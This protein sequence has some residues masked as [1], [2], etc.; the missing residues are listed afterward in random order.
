METRKSLKRTS[1]NVVGQSIVEDEDDIVDRR[2]K[3]STRENFT[4]RDE[5]MLHDDEHH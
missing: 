3:K 5:K 1:H 2:E 4:N